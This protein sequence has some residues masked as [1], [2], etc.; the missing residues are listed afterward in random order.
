MH[1]L[2][3]NLLLAMGYGG[4]PDAGQTTKLTG[5]EGIDGVINE[6]KLGLDRRLHSGKEVARREQ[7][8]SSFR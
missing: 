3:V 2:V 7:N 8:P 4:G 6:D 1:R 5:D